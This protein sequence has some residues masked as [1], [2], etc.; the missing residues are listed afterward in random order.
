MSDVHGVDAATR[1]TLD[2]RRD[3]LTQQYLQ[4]RETRRHGPGILL[5][6]L[7]HEENEDDQRHVRDDRNEES[8]APRDGVPDAAD[9]GTIVLKVEVHQ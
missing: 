5:K 1:A 7:R 3:A 6:E 2:A 8:F 9:V 4:P